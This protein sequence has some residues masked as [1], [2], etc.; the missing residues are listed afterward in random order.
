MFEKRASTAVPVEEIIARRW[1]GRSYDPARPVEREK[2]IALLEAARWAPSCFGDEPWRYLIWDRDADPDH[3]RRA[4]DCLTEGN[5]SWAGAAPILMLSVADSVFMKNAK[6]NRWG[7]HDTGAASMSLALQATALGLMVHQMGGFDAERIR[8]EFGI[9]ERYACMAA[10]TVGYQLPE[11][12]IPDEQRE[13]EYAPRARRP[14][15]QSF[16]RGTWEN[17]FE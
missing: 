13:R 2:L 3:W 14:L 10:I 5:R 12:A 16:F 6:A 7:Q 8:A 9:P 11:S 17:P 15:G 4:F 1:S